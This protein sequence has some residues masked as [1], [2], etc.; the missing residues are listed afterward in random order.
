MNSFPFERLEGES[1]LAFSACLAYCLMSGKRSV[2]AAQDIFYGNS[3][4]PSR[5]ENQGSRQWQNWCSRFHWVSRANLLD[6][7][8]ALEFIELEKQL[9]LKT[10]DDFN[11]IGEVKIQVQLRIE[12][13]FLNF[14][15]DCDKKGFFSCDDNDLSEVGDR[16]E[17]AA[18]IQKILNESDKILYDRF[19]KSVGIESLIPM[20]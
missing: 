14:L 12:T 9:W 16:L 11:K 13:I 18:K 17:N 10:K 15:K 19:L 6:Q 3:K 1:T 5:K 2:K 8:R 7:Q 4:A 20:D